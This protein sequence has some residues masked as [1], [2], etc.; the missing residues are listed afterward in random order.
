MIE[1]TAELERM[2]DIQEEFLGRR[3][4]F[5]ALLTNTSCEAPSLDPLLLTY[6]AAV[7]E[8]SVGGLDVVSQD[9]TIKWDYLQSVFFATTILT[10]IGTTVKLLTARH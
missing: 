4:Q 8:A 6:E 7:S 5:L 9:F 1:Q 2:T 3:Q 10:T